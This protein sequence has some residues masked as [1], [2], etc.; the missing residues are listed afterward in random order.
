M[1]ALAFDTIDVPATTRQTLAVSA[2]VGLALLP[3]VRHLEWEV[4]AFVM[5][6]L[7][8]RIAALRWTALL[9]GR[10]VLLLLTLAGLLNCVVSTRGLDARAGGTAVL[11]TMVGLKLL[12]LRTRR[13]HRILAIVLLL[14]VVVQFL[15]DSDLW[16]AVFLAGITVMAIGLLVNLNGGLGQDELRLTVRVT[17]LLAGHAVPLMLVFFLLFP[18]LDSPLWN[19]GLD[20]DRHVTGLG[21]SLEPGSV[22]ELV[23]NGELAFRARFSGPAPRAEQLYWR[24]RVLWAVDDQRWTAGTRGM[25]SGPAPGLLEAA[26]PVS[27]EVLFEPASKPWLV[28]LDLPVSWPAGIALDSSFQL[29]A[30]DGSATMRRYAVTSA[31]SYRT[32]ENDAEER[33]RGLQLPPSISERQRDLAERWRA[34]VGSDWEM[35]LAGLSHFR[36]GDF[37][38][39]LL[40][41]RLRGNVWDAF[42]FDSRNGFCEHYAGS[43]AVMMRLAGIPARVVVG[44][45]GGE[46]NRFGRHLMIWQ[47]DAHAW[48]EVLI[49]G[50]GWVRVDPTMAVSA[51]ALGRRNAVLLEG[52]QGATRF[53]IDRGGWLGRSLRQLRDL[54]D[55]M[56]TVWE[57]WVLDFSLGRQEHILEGLGLGGRG[58]Q[59]LV[60]LMLGTSFLATGLMLLS[61]LRAP[62]ESDR[63]IRYYRVFCRRLAATGFARSPKEGEGDY[64]KRV[65]AA[66][67][68][69]AESV[70]EITGLYVRHRYGGG[71]DPGAQVTFRRAVRRFRPS[72]G[73]VLAQRE[74]PGLRWR[75]RPVVA[76][77][78]D[79]ESREDAAEKI[80]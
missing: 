72:W 64:A 8:L 18:R 33:T 27:Y 6:I 5:L 55:A 34:G 36:N 56:D 59:A 37:Q 1:R 22:A 15:F 57:E 63:W 75:A 31:L 35:V 50:R 47:S 32:A 48:T 28:A 44:Y 80:I 20:H 29:T 45:L 76:L 69:L 19:L 41:A 13:D 68:D 78:P 4:T 24:G 58:Y 12:E 66:R 3:L 10:W 21:D 14:L 46:S 43:F 52:G 49:S 79:A 2:I 62:R 74:G 26:E 60:V 38:Y 42:L 71:S 25:K 7:A 77:L 23:I 61:L 73:W 39:T 67:P 70:L 40:P 65:A 30:P 51:G 17:A 9:P 53:G 54:S 16:L 11:V